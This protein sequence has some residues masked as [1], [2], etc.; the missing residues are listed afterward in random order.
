MRRLVYAIY[1]RADISISMTTS[2]RS[3]SIIWP[4][5]ICETLPVENEL[6]DGR[7]VEVLQT[8]KS[9]ALSVS[10]FY[11]QGRH[12]SPRV[13]VF[14]DWLVHLYAQRFGTHHSAAS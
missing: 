2:P 1:V 3:E 7:L 13:R 6:A 4:H 9:P 12:L 5:H 10:A 8:W 14:I 11:P